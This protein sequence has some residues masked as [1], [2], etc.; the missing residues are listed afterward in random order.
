[1]LS[2]RAA[3]RENRVAVCLNLLLHEAQPFHA[4][5]NLPPLGPVHLDVV[6]LEDRV[7]GQ[8]DLQ[9]EDV[10]PGLPI[11]HAAIPRGIVPDHAADPAQVLTSGIGTEWHSALREIR[12]QLGAEG[13]G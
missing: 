5:D 2:D 6:R 9:A 13:A 10:I 1:M 4:A 8:E 7:V 11:L 3:T 12:A